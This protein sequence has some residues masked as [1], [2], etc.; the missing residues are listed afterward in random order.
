MA[1]G[2][3]TEQLR[4]L[5]LPTLVIHGQDDPLV[6][7][8]G[9]VATAQA[10]PGAELIAIPGMGHDLPRQVGPLIGDAVARNAERAVAAA[11]A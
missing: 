10:I 1:S 8:R 9:G 11:P 6:P 7:F 5:R 2:D 3:R 4:R